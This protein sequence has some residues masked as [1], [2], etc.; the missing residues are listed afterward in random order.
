MTLF[1][2]RLL[3]KL[4]LPCCAL[5][6]FNAAPVQG[7]EEIS[8]EL[9]KIDEGTAWVSSYWG[10]NAPK[11]VYDGESFYTVALWG[12]EQATATGA[13]YKFRDGR[14]EKG[15]TWEGLNYQPGM[16]LLDS[17]Q[18]IILI[19]PQMNAAP[20][21]LRALSRGDIHNFESIPA[22]ANINKAGYLGA[23]IFDDRIVL[24]YIGDPA[25]YSFN[26]ATLDLETGEWKGP[27]LLAPAQRQREPWTTWLYPIIVPD[28]RGFHLTVSNQPDPAA[29]YDS[30]LYMYLPYEPGDEP[31]PE[32]IAQAN[33]WTGH[34]AFG[35]AMWRAQD[36]SLYVTAQY[37]PEGGENQLHLYRR[38]PLTQSW[39]G[40]AISRSQIA[41]IFQDKNQ[42]LWLT[43]TYWDALRLYAPKDQ[44]ATWE[45]VK[46][47]EFAPYGLVSSFFLH[48]IHPG[49]GSVMPAGPAAVFSAGTHPQYQLW[50]VHFATAGSPTAIA[51]SNT[52]L[53]PGY[54]LQQNYPNP[55][56]SATT[57]R[58]ALPVG[59]KID[60]SI[61]NLQ[62][63]KV[64]RLATGKQLAA[65]WHQVRWEGL[66]AHRR[67]LSSGVY[68]YRLECGGKAIT[69]KLILLR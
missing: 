6:L 57:L 61:Y 21:V 43:S 9:S 3:S 28:E 4:G 37:K 46:L 31:A 29:S 40:Q 36:G 41:A 22:P 49:S 42:N 58:F 67:P 34:M 59:G 25:T 10:Y 11:L 24:G 53:P 51:Q 7:E 64:A 33:P 56:N 19:Y 54:E 44:G 69:R 2:P 50:F 16:L 13:L 30:I 8:Y 62:G 1:F 14:W 63:R 48:G 65:G 17:Q 55:F 15:F 60:L 32:V 26:V 45:A 35:E 66:D 39:S 18:R 47:P 5:L 38:D 68:F 12:G 52:T 20:V 23:G 27:H